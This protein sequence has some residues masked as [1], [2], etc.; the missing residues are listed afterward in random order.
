MG[1]IAA[2][3][4][5][6]C[7]HYPRI[8]HVFGIDC[9]P[10]R[11]KHA[12]LRFKRWKELARRF[13]G[14]HLEYQAQLL[15]VIYCLFAR[16]ILRRR[17]ISDGRGRRRDGQGNHRVVGGRL[18]G[19]GGCGIQCGG[20]GPQRVH[21]FRHFEKECPILPGSRAVSDSLAVRHDQ[22]RVI[23]R[24][25]IRGEHLA[26]DAG[27]ARRHDDLQR[28]GLFG[29]PQPR[30]LRVRQ[31]LIPVQ[32]NVQ[33]VGRAQRQGSNAEGTLRAGPGLLE[34]VV[35]CGAAGEHVYAAQRLACG[36]DDAAREGADGKI[37]DDGCLRLFLGHRPGGRVFADRI[38][39]DAVLN[40][41][42]QHLDVPRGCGDSP[43]RA[44]VILRRK[45]PPHLEPDL[46]DRGAIG[47]DERDVFDRGLQGEILGERRTRLID[48]HDVAP[49]L[50]H[51]LSRR[52]EVPGHGD[53]GVSE[54]EPQGIGAVFVR[55]DALRYGAGG[56]GHYGD[57]CQGVAIRVCHRACDFAGIIFRNGEHAFGYRTGPDGGGFLKPRLDA[58]G[59][60]GHHGEVL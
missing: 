38:V 51:V 60:R 29:G 13:V 46:F 44:P 18:N 59:G 55:S 42:A 37:E 8:N 7:I 54:R 23:Q 24:G 12:R 30:Y 50:D 52:E 53:P 25:A 26:G 10:F 32:V 27:V 5:F 48:L 41:L 3:D 36:I 9:I 40:A 16:R 11:R 21:A 43:P 47:P 35:L 4:A 34:G 45:D 33:I 22:M 57:A 58:I 31:E 6:L 17:N 20:D 56:A 14:K 2:S 28:G 19:H 1:E 15:H 49:R 39:R